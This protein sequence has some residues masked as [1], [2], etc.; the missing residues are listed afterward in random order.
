M[1]FSSETSPRMANP[2]AFFGLSSRGR[3]RTSAVRSKL[4]RSS[5]KSSQ[6]PTSAVSGASVAPSSALNATSSPVVICPSIASDAP[7]PSTITTAS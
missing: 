3:R 2:A 4:M 6:T 1:T 5:F 7:H